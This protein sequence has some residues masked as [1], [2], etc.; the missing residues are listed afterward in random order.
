MQPQN[1]VHPQIDYIIVGAG[2]S[3][4][5]IGLE[6]LKKNPRAIVVIL[7]KYFYVGGRIN[8]Y[9]T[10]VPSI[11]KVQWE[12]GA[13]RISKTHKKTLE[14]LKKYDLHTIS[15]PELTEYRGNDILSEPPS[16]ISFYKIM[17][18][19]ADVLSYSKTLKPNLGTKTVKELFEKTLSETMFV[20]NSFLDRFPYWAETN[21]LRA[22]LA[23]SS[24]CEDLNLENGF[25]VCKEGLGEL[26]NRMYLDFE[27]RGGILYKG[28]EVTSIKHNF[29]K[30]FDLVN[31]V[32]KNKKSLPEEVHFSLAARTTVLALHAQALANI[33]H[34]SV[35]DT[36]YPSFLKRLE[37]APLVRMYAVFPKNSDGNVWFANQ[38]HTIL[39]S[40]LRYFIPIRSD[41]GI[42]MIS[43]S[44][45]PDATH[46]IGKLNKE[47]DKS[48]Q[49]EVM[50]K[51]R[52]A[53]RDKGNIPDPIFFKIHPWY[54]GCTY[55]LP[56][57]Y[58]PYQESKKSLHPL[59]KLLPNTYVCSESTSTRQA[60]IEGALEQTEKLYSE[61]NILSESF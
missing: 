11:G 42:V 17:C 58:D 56:G 24:F 35:P 25:V 39:P 29:E 7:E 55:W 20:K 53:F 22:D 4:L 1:L 50:K 48:V 15:I 44:E 61:T 32:R 21:I 30:K 18:P 43:Y 2:I 33:F 10:T 57:N 41:L 59:P 27:K 23:L 13:G 51:I 52:H 37:M 36:Q 12:N 54:E 8:T 9:H 40:P 26:I 38:P 16:A 31:C 45:G 19:I 49:K 34:A 6:L 5:S 28:T 60:W 46:W 14:L 3:G 47:G